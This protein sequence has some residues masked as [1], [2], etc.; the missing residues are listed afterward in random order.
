MFY[1]WGFKSAVLLRISL[2]S[3]CPSTPRE[4]QHKQVSNNVIA[5]LLRMVCSQ[6]NRSDTLIIS[7]KRLG[8]G[9]L[10]ILFSVYLRNST[11]C[12]GSV[13]RHKEAFMYVPTGLSTY[14]L[15]PLSEQED[16]HIYQ[17]LQT[18]VGGWDSDDS[19]LSSYKCQTYKK[20][21][22]ESVSMKNNC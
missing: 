8:W 16:K 4:V 12:F 11:S 15:N 19:V 5:A 13:R 3:L 10:N 1:Y 9:L 14:H 17:W 6:C 7:T 21:T 2:G 20:N 22:D 18:S